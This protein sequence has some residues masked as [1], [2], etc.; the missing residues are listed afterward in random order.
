MPQSNKSNYVS[1]EQIDQAK[2]IDLLT[3][4]QSFEPQELVHLRGGIYCTKTH[5]SL[6]ISHGK[7]CW[8]SRHLGGKTALD[9]LIKVRGM[10]F[11]DAV[12]ML[13]STNQCLPPVSAALK[14]DMPRRL[15]TA[16]GQ[17]RQ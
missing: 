10:E 2:R 8:W 14:L 4:L 13:C 9:Y 16:Q 6:K 1:R 12:R 11:T 17:Q 15:R 7:W 5:D 3:Y